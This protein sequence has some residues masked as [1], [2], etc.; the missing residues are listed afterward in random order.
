M[1]LFQALTA[2]A[3]AALHRDL[4]NALCLICPDIFVIDNYTFVTEIQAW[5]EVYKVLITF[6]IMGRDAQNDAA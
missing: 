6:E 5:L 3:V 1:D 4:S 2:L